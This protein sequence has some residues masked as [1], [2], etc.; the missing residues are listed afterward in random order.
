[1]LTMLRC[2]YCCASKFF[3]IFC[4]LSGKNPWSSTLQSNKSQ[5]E[6][7]RVRHDAEGRVLLALLATSSGY[8][9]GLGLEITYK[10][11]LWIK[12]A[13]YAYHEDITVKNVHKHFATDVS[14]T[15]RNMEEDILKMCIR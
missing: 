10:R 2:S 3:L 14:N 13:F 1:M 15:R 6:L 12:K 11:T 5:S 4:L 7:R 9:G 8:H